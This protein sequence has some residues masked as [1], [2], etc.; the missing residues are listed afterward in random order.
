M[1]LRFRWT[2]E[3]VIRVCSAL[4]C[5]ILIAMA[6]PNPARAWHDD[7]WLPRHHSY[8]RGR[9]GPRFFVPPPVA[10][11]VYP[12]YYPGYYPAP[13]YSAPFYPAPPSYLPV[14]VP[15]LAVS[16]GFNWR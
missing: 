14:P 8:W 1:S 7:N 10:V 15:P 3:N 5:A 2:R 16:P 13:V 6:A 12:G 4:L 11:G 9:W